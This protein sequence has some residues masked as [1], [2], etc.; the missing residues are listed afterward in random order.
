MQEHLRPMRQEGKKDHPDRM[1]D[2]AKAFFKETWKSGF[3]EVDVFQ[4]Q[5]KLLERF[6]VPLGEDGRIEKKVR[7]AMQV[8][9][10]E[11]IHFV[12]EKRRDIDSRKSLAGYLQNLREVAFSVSPSI[13]NLLSFPDQLFFSAL[14]SRIPEAQG[15]IAPST[16]GE[17]GYELQYCDPEYRS[18]VLERAYAAGSI[19][20]KLDFL[21]F[22]V[23]IGADA[24]AQGWAD[25]AF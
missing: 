8:F 17:L 14:L 6:D 19:D 1:P 2:L 11:L 21:N 16:V 24:A 15:T 5:E 25:D 10:Q 22:L 3:Q 7:D 13:F 9:F 4:F 23:T 18:A 12:K 20:Q